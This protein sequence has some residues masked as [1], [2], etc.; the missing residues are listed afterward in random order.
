MSNTL[1]SLLQR[2]ICQ[3]RC[4]FAVE[5][6]LTEMSYMYLFQFG[7]YFHHRSSAEKI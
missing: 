2:K 4:L 6:C 1:G 5:F 7:L 3:F